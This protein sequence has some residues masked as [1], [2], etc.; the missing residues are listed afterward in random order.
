MIDSLQQVLALFLTSANT[1][2]IHIE[3]S[4][5]LSSNIQITWGR[6]SVM[7]GLNASMVTTHGEMEVP[8]F[9]A[10][11]GP[12]G[13]YSHFWIS[14]AEKKE[15]SYNCKPKNFSS[16]LYLMKSE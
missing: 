6:L 2:N 1:K 8:K 12:N 3:V 11:K 14:R 7:K 9:L 10:K 13:T 4:P 15:I 5:L 16:W